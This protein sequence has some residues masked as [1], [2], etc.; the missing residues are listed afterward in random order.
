M[1]KKSLLTLLFVCGVIVVAYS[2]IPQSILW[3]FLIGAIPGTSYSLSPI[4]MAVVLSLTLCA[5]TL[6]SWLTILS[7]QK[8]DAS[9]VKS[10]THTRRAPRRRYARTRVTV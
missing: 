8:Q 7:Q 6:Y 9:L 1:R 5:V 3:F 4:A 10:K 2:G